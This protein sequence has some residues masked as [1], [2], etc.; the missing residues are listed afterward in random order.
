VR[1]VVVRHWLA[2]ACCAVLTA[3]AAA[4]YQAPCRAHSSLAARQMAAE[5]LSRY[6]R[7]LRAQDSSAIA[8]MFVPDG[9]LEHVGQNPIVGRENIQAFLDSFA[10]YQVLSHDMNLASSSFTACRVSQSG[11]YVQH[12]RGPDGRE[13]TARGWFAFQWVEQADGRWLLESAQTSSSPIPGGT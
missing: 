4:P 9:R 12:V 11:S 3:C 6:A 5:A 2:T 13:I 7:L 1:A 8:Q 10:G